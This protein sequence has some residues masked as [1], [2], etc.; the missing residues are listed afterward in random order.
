MWG[1]GAEG[2]GGGGCVI[3]N[4]LKFQVHGGRNMQ[5]QLSLVTCGVEVW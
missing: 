1:G 4:L 3:G 2:G 5:F